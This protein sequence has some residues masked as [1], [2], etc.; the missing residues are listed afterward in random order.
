MSS[1][2]ALNA[3]DVLPKGLLSKLQR[4]CSGMI[5][6]PAPQTKAQMRLTRVRIL[7]NRG[8]EPAVISGIVGLSVGRVRDIIRQLKNGRISGSQSEYKIYESVPREIVE[9]V[10][11]Y[12][13]GHMYVPPK[14]TQAD[15]RRS[16]VKKLL[17]KNIAVG[18]IAQ[19]TGLSERRIWQ[20]KKAELEAARYKHTSSNTQRRNVRDPLAVDPDFKIED[21]DE[22]RLCPTC[23]AVLGPDEQE[24][25]VCKWLSEK[26][27]AENSDEIVLSHFPFSVIE[28]NF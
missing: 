14:A 19:R 3:K 25:E 16:R 12:A 11:R 26:A 27:E 18:E 5:Y 24:C 10:Q 15:R 22:P 28:R 21:Y 23:R 4:Y 2:L 7:H 20:I 13:F 9:T 8:N 17:N 1:R 6:I